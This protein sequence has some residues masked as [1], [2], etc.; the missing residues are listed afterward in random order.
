[1]STS[2]YIRTKAMNGILFPDKKK[3]E[4]G[5]LLHDDCM[6][7]YVSALFNTRLTFINHRHFTDEDDVAQ[8][9][10]PLVVKLIITTPDRTGIYLI[11]EEDKQKI[12]IPGGHVSKEDVLYIQDDLGIKDK[13]LLILQSALNRE[14]CEEFFGDERGYNYYMSSKDYLTDPHPLTGIESVIYRKFKV[15]HPID[16]IQ[17]LYY[18]YKG[19]NRQHSRS[20]TFYY[21]IEV[22][23]IPGYMCPYNYIWLSKDDFLLSCRR[24]RM[25]DIIS[26]IGDPIV[27]VSRDIRFSRKYRPILDI[28]F[29][30]PELF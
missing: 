28:I 26:I 16:P 9:Y 17:D 14:L 1:M 30:T 3:I 6:D 10:V 20:L 8:E 5:T 23:T 15:C 7:D 27:P 21:V 12:S 2:V 13:S 25:R 18:L 4:T 19:K 22:E 11:Y 29:N 24:G